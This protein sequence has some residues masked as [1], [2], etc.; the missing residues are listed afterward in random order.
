MKK[1]IFLTVEHALNKI[2]QE[3]KYLHSDKELIHSGKAYDIGALKVAKIVA[4]HFNAHLHKNYVSRLLVDCNRSPRNKKAILKYIYHLPKQEKQV[5]LE[6]FYYPY[7]NLGIKKLKY[8][9]NNNYQIL[10]IALHSFSQVLD[11]KSRNNDIALLYRPWV[12][13]EKEFCHIWAEEIKKLDQNILLR[14]NYPYTGK[15]DCFTNYCGDKLFT[16]RKRFLGIF[17]ELNQKNMTQ[18]SS[19]N[20][21]TQIIIKSLENT[22]KRSNWFKK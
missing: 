21:I 9:Y 18:S 2:P 12:K 11:N 3:Y 16:N 14:F 1:I 7:W 20:K 8:F 13:E 17:L 4:K 6:K 10:N 22:L 15:S 19:R 5:I